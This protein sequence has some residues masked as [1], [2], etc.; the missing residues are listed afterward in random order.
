MSHA[1][2]SGVG[3]SFGG[4][5]ALDGGAQGGLFGDAQATGAT[6][7]HVGADLGGE[8]PH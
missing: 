5:G 7:S 1:F 2:G 4:T 6:E 8:L 3:A